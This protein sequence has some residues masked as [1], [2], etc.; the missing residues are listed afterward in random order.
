MEFRQTHP[1]ALKPGKEKDETITRTR[2]R[3]KYQYG[4]YA[5][6]ILSVFL[7][8]SSTFEDHHISD[9]GEQSNGS[10]PDSFSSTSLDASHSANKSTV[11]C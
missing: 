3:E 6:T 1:G 4:G 11:E 2:N 5:Y 8:F 9:L 10:A 7:S